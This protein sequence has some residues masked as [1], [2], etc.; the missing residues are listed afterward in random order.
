[1]K[2]GIIEMLVTQLVVGWLCF[3]LNI[4]TFAMIRVHSEGWRL[5]SFML[6]LLGFKLATGAIFRARSELAMVERQH[7]AIA[8]RGVY[9]DETD[10]PG[11]LVIGKRKVIDFDSIRDCGIGWRRRIKIK[12]HDSP[13]TSSEPAASKTPDNVHILPDIAERSMFVAPV[14]AMKARSSRLAG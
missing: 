1:M 2:R 10:T 6:G 13:G 4:V 3:A 12:V 14:I 11:I 8:H 5:I 9:L 7:V